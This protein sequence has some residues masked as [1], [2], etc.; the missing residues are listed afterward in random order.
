MSLTNHPY[1]FV[2]ERSAFY[3]KNAAILQSLRYTAI[4]QV[5]A[6]W[7]CADSVW[8]EDGPM[9]VKTL[10]GILS[11]HVKSECKIAVGWN[12]FSL[13]EN[14]TWFDE[15]QRDQIDGRDRVEDSE[16]RA[17]GTVS[18]I[19]G[20]R[21]EDI[22][23]HPCDAGWG[24]GIGLKCGSG[25]CLWIYDAGDVIAAKVGSPADSAEI[26]GEKLDCAA[27]LGDPAG[28]QKERGRD[29]GRGKW[30]GGRL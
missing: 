3:R 9:L 25:R 24:V 4:E 29:N 7:D 15:T 10:A 19:C 17:Y 14:P 5:Y 16:W 22:L 8:F 28:S 6:L 12:D 2:S 1:D 30:E 21:V 20:E 23:F 11:V 27:D 13:R 18:Q 26:C